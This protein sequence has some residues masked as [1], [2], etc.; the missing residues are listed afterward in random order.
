MIKLE[1]IKFIKRKEARMDNWSCEDGK[2]ND[3]SNGINCTRE[4]RIIE[5]LI[6]K[7]RFLAEELK[8]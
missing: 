7:T 1:N 4:N 6:E 2:G 3:S 8:N 5:N